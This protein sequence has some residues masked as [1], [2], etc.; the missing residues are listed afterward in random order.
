VKTSS[1]CT[2]DIIHDV[3]GSAELQVKAPGTELISVSLEP[4]ELML[5]LVEV[6]N[7]LGVSREIELS[8]RIAN[9]L[10]RE[11]NKRKTR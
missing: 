1:F 8:K 11:R 6:G 2:L 3:S 10:E 4:D 9:D 7:S 5:F